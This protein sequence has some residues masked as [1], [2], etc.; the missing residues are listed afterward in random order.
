MEG[1]QALGLP[2]SDR[3]ESVFS[4]LSLQ[5]ESSSLTG[6]VVGGEEGQEG[7]GTGRGWAGP[8]GIG[9]VGGGGQQSWVSLWWRVGEGLQR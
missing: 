5:L 4:S 2:R 1:K 3:I 8:R 7:P 9:I 6:T